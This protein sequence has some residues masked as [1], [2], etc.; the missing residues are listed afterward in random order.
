MNDPAE[1][2]NMDGNFD[3]LDC[4]GEDG[5]DGAQ[6]PQGPEG[7]AGPQGPAGNDGNDGMDG[8][9]GPQ[10]PEGPT[11]P[12][13][14][15]GNDGSNG[16]DGINC[17]DTNGDGI[18]DPAE[19][20]NMD[21]N[22][23]ALDCQGEDGMD[24]AQ[25]PQGPEGP[26]G[27]QG[28]AGNDGNDGMDGAQGPQG[29]EG[30]AGPQGPAGIDGND[31]M[32]GAQG[33][34]GPEGPTGPQ[35]PAG[36]DGSNGT[37]GINCWDTNGDGI[38]DPAEDIN[39]DGNFDALDCQ[40]ADGMDGAQGPQGPEGPTGPQGPAGND[41]S[42]GTD[43]INCWDTNGDG[44]NDPAEDTNMDGNFDALDCQGEDGMDGA[45]GPQG[46]EGPTGPQGPAGNDGNDGMDG[47]QGPQGPEGPTGPQGPAG[48][49]GSNGTDGINC[50][51]TNGDGINDPA[52]DTNMDGN[53][54]ALDC[55]GADGMDGAQGPQ[56]P[57]GPTGP[58]GPA[59]N[60]GN[61]GMD[62]AQG[63]AG[64]QGPEGPTG[65]QGPAG[66]PATADGNGIYDG[67]GTT[68]SMT[69][70]SLTDNLSFDDNTLHIDGSNDR[71]G[72][73]TDSPTNA[74]DVIGNIG[75]S[76]Q[77]F[78]LS[79]ERLKT[80]KAPILNASG[81]LSQLNPVT[82][83]FKT[84]KFNELN[85]PTSKQYGLMA[86]EVEK[87]LPEIVA[88][89]ETKDNESLKSVNYDALIAILIG[90]LNE[91]QS[92]IDVLE[93]QIQSLIEDKK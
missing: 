85:L 24:G 31:G 62:G 9:Q 73:G 46:P 38:N 52:E 22:F 77:I 93:A 89:M 4:Q 54:D 72:I 64:P 69:Q 43:G 55:Q 10:G 59:G 68:P 44:I 20:T 61:D 76:G 86:Q 57:E 47:A 12:Q 32:D 50:W 27:P 34:Q 41:G 48:N 8:A 65:P 58:Q 81:I 66:D 14:P 80:N 74:L 51:D 29:P 23:D 83:N 67:N 56:G 15:A 2:I 53:F 7:P 19:D 13:G 17:W 21:G 35:G 92:R 82:Y 11:G 39:M 30:P 90:A 40:G 60:D 3:A 71:V 5:M 88:Q 36:N 70:V 75:V 37:D 91:Q 79:D 1:D 42:N 26:T 6:G 16:T 84:D 25:G 78:G 63:P 87:V 49:D 18:N 33:P 45:Q 28:P